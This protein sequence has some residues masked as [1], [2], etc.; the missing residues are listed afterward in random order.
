[1]SC[2][3]IKVATDYDHTVNFAQYESYAF[4]KPG[5]DKVDISDLDK[6]RIL[7]AIEAEMEK[8]GF[9]K[10]TEQPDLLVSFFTKT[11]KNVNISSGYYYGFQ[12]RSINLRGKLFINL[13]DSHSM[14]LIWQ[15]MGSGLLKLDPDYKIKFINKLV[16]KI[17][18]P[19]PPG[20]KMD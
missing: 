10:T 6:R 3:S 16:H 13:V 9:K 17:L 2:S 12:N 1:M 20:E 4:Y 7:R 8:M 5:I 18:A 11:T 15:G 14:N 19:Y